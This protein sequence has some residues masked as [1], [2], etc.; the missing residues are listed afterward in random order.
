MDEGPANDSFQDKSLQYGGRQNGS[1]PTH[2]GAHRDRRPMLLAPVFKDRI[3]GGDRLARE[4]GKMTAL[5]PIA[6]SWE[7]SC[8]PDGLSI[9]RTG[10]YAGRT[11]AE[12][13]DA[14][15]GWAGP[16]CSGAAGFPIL[17]KLIDAKQN[18]S[19]QV[20]PGDA[21]ARAHE[22]DNGK[23]EAW[24]VVDCE[25]D[26]RLILGLKADIDAGEI[27]SRLRDGTILECVNY[28]PVKP[29][30]C[31]CVPAGLLHAICGGV[32]IAEVQQSSNVTYRVHDYG[33]LGA[34]GKPRKLHIE[35][36]ADVVN[37]ELRVANCA[38]GAA[39]R[40]L[41]GYSDT[42]L[43]NWRF[44]KLNKLDIGGS[45]SLCC[46]SGGFHSLLVTGG[47]FTVEADGCPPVAAHK[48]GCV[49][50]PSGLGAYTLR[51][52]GCVLLASA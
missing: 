17:V 19:L 46:G 13:I 42:E 30:D 25:P 50:I 18:L 37:G 40:V 8:H 24:Y 6:E 11:L 21:Y 3:W 5:R 39:V 31:Y 38:D 45:A 41:E 14:H 35:Q 20:H 43:V 4:F 22:N 10:E 52:H 29:G 27:A 28:E 7:L 47:D 49:F 34:D 1:R 15:P 51:G 44:F 2:N 33:R 9:I 36:A 16:G 26:A 48:G 23:N 12:A 32:L